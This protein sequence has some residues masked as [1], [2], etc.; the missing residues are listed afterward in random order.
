MKAS[1]ISRWM[2][3]ALVSDTTMCQGNGSVRQKQGK[4]MDKMYRVK[5]FKV[6]QLFWATYLHCRLELNEYCGKKNGL[7]KI[8]TLVPR[9]LYALVQSHGARTVTYTSVYLLSLCQTGGDEIELLKIAPALKN[10][11][12]LFNSIPRVRPCREAT[13]PNAQQ[14]QCLLRSACR[15]WARLPWRDS[16]AKQAE[17]TV[18]CLTRSIHRS[19]INRAEYRC[20]GDWSRPP[21]RFWRMLGPL[22]GVR[23][24]KIGYG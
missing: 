20:F 8:L 24:M 7:F 13:F 17:R 5:Q 3:C 19:R 1:P 10:S 12:S 9:S 4:K 14:Q 16:A 2:T 11:S 21:P 6:I 18:I 15:T 23:W 22:G